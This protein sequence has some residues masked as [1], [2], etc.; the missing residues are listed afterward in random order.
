MVQ[1]PGITW[2]ARRDFF[3]TTKVADTNLRRRDFIPSLRASL[4]R[5]RVENVGMTAESL[6]TVHSNLDSALQLA[7]LHRG[8]P[9]SGHPQ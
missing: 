3:I 5:L 7:G 8:R 2:M 4:E 6:R 1:K 9:F